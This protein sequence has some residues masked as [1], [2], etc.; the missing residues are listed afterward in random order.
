MITA[1]A[2]LLFYR[3]RSAAPLGGP[4]F[5]SIIDKFDNASSGDDDDDDDEAS[6]PGEGQRLDIGSSRLGLS[7]ALK[8]AEATRHLGGLGLAS[9]TDHVQDAPDVD[10]EELP[11]PYQAPS[12]AGTD[13][14]ELDDDFKQ[15]LSGYLDF[16]KDKDTSIRA[17]VEDE[18]IGGMGTR[19]LWD[20]P[21]WG[22]T[23]TTDDGTA[24]PTGG[25]SDTD[26]NSMGPGV[27]DH[28]EQMSFETA[29][30]EYSLPPEPTAPELPP[31][32]TMEGVEP[33]DPVQ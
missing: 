14:I 8:G 9:G 2:Y 12:D 21:H 30:D 29:H 11:P 22:W 32:N 1:A 20:T 26:V 4:R 7:S 6:E 25:S 18:G 31:E 27:G 5:Q 3:R 23:K 13:N 28:D 33:D 17:S 19:A 24:Q 16:G 10:V 15:P